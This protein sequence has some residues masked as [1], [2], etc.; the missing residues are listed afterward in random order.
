MRRSALGRGLLL[1]LAPA[2]FGADRPEILGIAHI[3]LFVHDIAQSRAFYKDFLGFDEPFSLKN[4]DGSL[5]LTWMKVNDAQAIELFPER[6]ANSDRLYL[7][8]F[9]VSDA[10]QMRQYLAGKDIPVP[11]SVPLGKSGTP[12]F[13]IKDPDGHSIEFVQYA[14]ASWT[15]KDYGQ[16]LSPNRVSTRMPHVGIMVRHLDR[17]LAFYRDL[18]GFTETW[19]GSKNGRVLNWVNL[20]VPNGKDYVELMLYGNDSQLARRTT[21]HHI[22]LEVPDVFATE[23]LL[24]TRQP[25]PGTKPHSPPAVGVNGRR[26]INYYDPDATRVEVMEPTT[27]NGKSVP[28]SSATPPGDQ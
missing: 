14:P 28:S 6:Q 26:Q 24:A 27:A 11:D 23:K 16:H 7:V 10:E 13:S 21:L 9:Q 2:A 22:C 3:G 8:S 15:A 4:K 25:P 19:R 17:T 12:N 18:L 1:G 5:R 20:R